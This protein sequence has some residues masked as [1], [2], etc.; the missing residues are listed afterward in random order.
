MRVLFDSTLFPQQA[1]G[2]D[3]RVSVTLG[4]C[5]VGCRRAGGVASNDWDVVCRSACYTGPEGEI[6]RG[7]RQSRGGYRCQS[8]ARA[9][10]GCA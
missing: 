1:A 2:P 10:V 6:H 5:C 7:D 9:G 4:A 3:T 8:L